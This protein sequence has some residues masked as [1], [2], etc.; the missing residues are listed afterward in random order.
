MKNKTHSYSIGI[1]TTSGFCVVVLLM[2][3]L[4]VVGLSHTSQVNSQMKNIVEKNN[5]KIALA[6]VMQRALHE[7]ALSMHAIAVL[8]DPFAKDEEYMRFNRLGSQYF[9]ARES[10]EKLIT[11][12]EER[13]ILST[14]KVLTRQTQ[15]DVQ[16]VI[17]IGLGLRKSSIPIFDK[18]RKH[19][20]PKQRLIAE[21]V[22]RLVALQEIQATSALL[23]AQSSY[24]RVR[25]LMVL[26]G[27]LAVAI[28]LFVSIY[29]IRRV[30]SQAKQ[31]EYRA[32]HDELTGLPNRVLFYDRL[33]KAIFSSQREVKSFSIILIDLNRFKPVND[34]YGHNVGDLL[35][36]EVA[37]RLKDSVRKADTVARL[38]GDEYMILFESL[39]LESALILVEKIARVFSEPFLLAGKA[40]DV[41]ASMGIACYP[42]HG[43]DCLTLIN[44]ADAAMYEA[45]R[46][47]QTYICYHHDMVVDE[48]KRKNSK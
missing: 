43:Q 22:K 35:L 2:V 46:K 3:A 26:L 41:G 20:I 29:V 42:E 7:R 40:L 1:R 34:L 23:K 27:S 45:K 48:Q 10:L 30:T 14:I 39:P 38:G 5:A 19:A 24:K 33:K 31:L 15:P 25:N 6:Q 11:T 8:E 17:E 44:H 32:L 18:I 9:S 13:D 12:R 36:R 16:S 28:G 21:Q 47:G 37:R 4:S